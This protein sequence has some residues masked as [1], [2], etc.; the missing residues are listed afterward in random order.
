M[1]FLKQGQ[2]VWVDADTLIECEV[3]ETSP[4]DN[5]RVLLEPTTDGFVTSAWVE[6]SRVRTTRVY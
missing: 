6:K 5:D 3:V 4:E 1:M 2:I